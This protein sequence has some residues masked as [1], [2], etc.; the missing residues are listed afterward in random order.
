MSDPLDPTRWTY[1]WGRRPRMG[2]MVR[3]LLADGSGDYYHSPKLYGHTKKTGWKY[4]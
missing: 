2:A 3:Y 1:E 4:K